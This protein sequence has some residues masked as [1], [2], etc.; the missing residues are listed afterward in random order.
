M[1]KQAKEVK[2]KPVILSLAARKLEGR[3]VG[4]RASGA[5]LQAEMSPGNSQE[6]SS[7]FPWGPSSAPENSGAFRQGAEQPPEAAA[8]GVVWDLT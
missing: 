6:I 8:N 2:F 1:E 5:I 7:T 4:R 3:E